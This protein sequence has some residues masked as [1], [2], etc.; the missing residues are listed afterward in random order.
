MDTT[1]LIHVNRSELVALETIRYH[2]TDTTKMVTRKV[3][4]R[5]NQA[6]TTARASL[7]LRSRF[8][9]ASPLI[10]PKPASNPLLW[11]KVKKRV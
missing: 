10:R 7:A 11:W 1:T 2:F 8:A 9:P 5:Q 4:V 3:V 6:D